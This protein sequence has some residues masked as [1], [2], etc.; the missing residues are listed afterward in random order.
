MK[1]NKFEILHILAAL[2]AAGMTASFFFA[3]NYMTVHTGK[4]FIDFDTLMANHIGQ[5]DTLS[6]FIQLYILGAMGAAMLHFTLLARWFKGFSVYRKSVDYQNLVNSNREVQLMAIP[7]TLTMTMNVFFILGALL[8]PGLFDSITVFGF[9]MQLIDPM[10][11]A[12]GLYFLGVFILALK[13]FGKYF[14]RLIDGELDFVQNANLSQL[15]AIFAFGMV[16]VGFGALGFSKIPTL[17]LIG[18]SMGYIVLGLTIVL[19]ILK[20]VLGFKSIFEH[21]I[22]A[23]D[24]VTLLIPITVIA[25]L[26]VGA[27]RADIGAMHALDTARSTAYHLILFTVG[28]G[29][30]VLIGLFG[31]SAMR[32]KGFFTDS[33]ENMNQPSSLALICPGFAL[34]VL[35]V[36]WLSIGLVHS[37]IVTHGTITYFMMWIPMIALQWLTIYFFFKLLK[38]NRFL[39][40]DF[41]FLRNLPKFQSKCIGCVA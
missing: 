3:I 9:T 2:G 1:N 32:R 39:K 23:K 25:M 18:S 26:A 34:E 35:L 27:Y 17:A 30:S 21:G 12:A 4:V 28:I 22:T 10:F 7:L 15:L 36:L 14:M 11:M 29:V 8:I 6:L 31:L 38:K 19:S 40:F 37:G 41:D 24:S 33:N 5:T 20:F 13:I 16:G